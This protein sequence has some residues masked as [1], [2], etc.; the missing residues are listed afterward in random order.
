MD[1]GYTQAISIINAKEA[2]GSAVLKAKAKATEACKIMAEIEKI[3]ERIGDWFATADKIIEVAEETEVAYIG[4][5]VIFNTFEPIVYGGIVTIDKKDVVRDT[6]E[7]D[8][9]GEYY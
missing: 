6:E 4:R 9:N 8:T 1:L 7:E 2:H 5:E 3:G